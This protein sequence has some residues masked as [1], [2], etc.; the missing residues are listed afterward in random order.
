MRPKSVIATILLISIFLA[1]SCSRNLTPTGPKPLPRAHAHNDYE[2]DRPLYDALDHG[3]TSVEADIH[4]VD[5]QLYVAHD[6]DEIMPNRTLRSLYLEPLSRR[7]DQN[8]GQVYPNGPQFTLF[9]DIKTEAVA[10]YKVL[11]KMLA[12]YESIF[13]TFDSNVRTDK[14]VIAIVSGNRPRG[15][16][17]SEPIRYAGCDGRLVDLESD[18]PATLVPIISDNWSK[19]FS[20]NG[21]GSMSTEERR[22]LKKIV[23]TAHKK[24]QRV[25]FWATPDRPT[26]AR[27]MLWRELLASG[28]DLLNTDDLQGLQQFLLQ[29]TPK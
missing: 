26:Q 14:A 3:F 23:E 2:H 16:M 20:Y 1:G 15:L 18:A 22:K 5:G 7:I 19:H 4:L 8:A 11:S 25:R 9:I 10:T 6:S 17:E 27:Q 24:G 29:H 13:T 21:A 12:E 28:V